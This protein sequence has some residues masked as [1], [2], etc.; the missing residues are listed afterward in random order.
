[1][2]ILKAARVV[3][4]SYRRYKMKPADRP[5]VAFYTHMTPKASR[6]RDPK[7]HLDKALRFH[8]KPGHCGTAIAPAYGN[9]MTTEVTVAVPSPSKDGFAFSSAQSRGR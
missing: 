3:E 8:S 2:Q 9:P 1:M 5:T 6:G 7:L 4:V